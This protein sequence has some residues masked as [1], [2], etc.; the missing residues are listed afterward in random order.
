MKGK[1][2]LILGNGFDLAH[3]LSTSYLNFLKF[4]Y[5][6]SLIA[7]RGKGIFL[8]SNKDIKVYW[9]RNWKDE[10]EYIL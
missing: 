4:N 3:G 10:V 7:K 5:I 6:F 2:I 1:K 8:K 9:K